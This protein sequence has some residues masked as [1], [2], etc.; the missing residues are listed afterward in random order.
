MEQLDGTRRY[1]HAQRETS[2]SKHSRDREI[3]SRRN[4][5]LYARENHEA[6]S[7]RNEHSRETNRPAGMNRFRP[8]ENQ[9]DNQKY[10]VQKHIISK[11]NEQTKNNGL[12]S[13]S[14]ASLN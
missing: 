14:T 3:G 8:R 9:Y 2:I 12:S 13:L 5:V 1:V 6:E 4:D 10:L 11:I 7:R